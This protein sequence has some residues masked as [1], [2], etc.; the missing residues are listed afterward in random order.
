[1]VRRAAARGKLER[2]IVCANDSAFNLVLLMKIN[3]IVA[4][5]FM[6]EMANWSCGWLAGNPEMASPRNF[7]IADHSGVSE[8]KRVH[9]C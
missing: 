9:Q 2:E 8:G 7:R 4:L 5:H 1:M 3:H 6:Q